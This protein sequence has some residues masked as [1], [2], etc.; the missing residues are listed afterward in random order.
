M[1]LLAVRGRSSG[2]RL[3]D[4]ALIPK[5]NLDFKRGDSAQA[6]EVVSGPVAGTD[7][8]IMALCTP[9]PVSSATGAAALGSATA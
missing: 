8:K 7:L 2:V 6:A 4:A 5:A 9:E 3:A 1:S